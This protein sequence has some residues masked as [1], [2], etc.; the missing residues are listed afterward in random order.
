MDGFFTQRGR[1][2]VV[3]I[4]FSG[5][6]GIVVFFRT[7]RR[8]LLDLVDSLFHGRRNVFLDGL[9]AIGCDGVFGSSRG[10]IRTGEGEAG[11]SRD[12]ASIRDG[13]ERAVK[14]PCQRDSTV[15]ARRKKKE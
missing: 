5:V 10:G 15:V 1:F 7:F 11:G 14:S 6:M 8:R 9:S 12:E 4:R 3:D 13:A 2:E